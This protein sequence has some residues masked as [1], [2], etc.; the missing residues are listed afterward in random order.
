MSEDSRSLPCPKKI[1][2]LIIDDEPL[3]RKR[4]RQLLDEDQ[5]FEILGEC[6]DGRHA[7]VEILERRPDLIFLD[8]G[9]PDINGFEVLQ[10]IDPPLMP[11][12]IFVAADDRPDRR[13]L[14]ALL[15]GC[16]LKPIGRAQ[17][18]AASRRI[19]DD[20]R[21]K[22]AGIVKT[23]I[24]EL[25]HELRKRR[26]LAYSDRLAVDTERGIE[27]VPMDEILWLEVPRREARLYTDRGSYVIQRNLDE[28]EEIVD[29]A[30]FMRI[31]PYAIVRIRAV[32][33]C[34]S[35][36]KR[37]LVLMLRDG[38]K[39]EVSASYAKK[40]VRRSKP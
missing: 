1:R 4:I 17:F 28:I 32:Q 7:V 11:W 14:A 12:V 23:R 27:L 29:P 31:S 8:V 40:V 16:L 33:K 18:L 37:Q 30:K 19:K 24:Q 3:A 38:T 34:L 25:L 9:I 5:D 39:L 36:G 21:V 2:V 10:L 6:A 20:M 22:Q 15:T 13:D 35:G 26:I